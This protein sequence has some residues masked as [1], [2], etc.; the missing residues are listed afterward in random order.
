MATHTNVKTAPSPIIMT[1]MIKGDVPAL[2]NLLSY[3]RAH[4]SPGEKQYILDHIMPLK[5]HVISTETNEPMAFFIYVGESDIMFTSHVDSVHMNVKE[6]YQDVFL[7]DG[8]FCKEDNQPLGADD[9]AGN[10]LMFNMI[11]AKVPGV[12][13]FFRGEERGGI[14]SSYCAKHRQDLFKNI[15]CAIAFDR[16]GTH[17]I[18]THQGGERGCSDEFTKSLSNI[19]GMGHVGDSTGLYTDTKEFF[20][21]VTNCTNV[22][23]GYEREHSKNETLKK[24]YICF[25]RDALIKADWSKLDHTAPTPE[26][27][28][29]G[30]YESILPLDKP[31]KSMGT[32]L[33]ET[34]T[35]IGPL[36]VADFLF[37]NCE[38]LPKD[39]R[40]EA[41][42]LAQKIYARF[43]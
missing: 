8:L 12:Y 35:E 23:V 7:K 3:R 39:L 25:L 43:E 21:I 11:H 33:F 24:E 17:S 41:L 34:V 4:N 29:Y 36:D 40:D 18:I 15:K 27:P 37:D 19:L 20:D 22:S 2:Y 31:G 38:E 14:G 1:K 10:W 28:F 42:E 13:A 9:A 16:R 32:S 6:I 5:P 30:R 26:P